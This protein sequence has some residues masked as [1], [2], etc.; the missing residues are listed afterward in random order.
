MNPRN[1]NSVSIEMLRGPCFGS[2]PVYSLT[3][4]GDGL[5][6]YRGIR[7]V[8]VKEKQTTRASSE[9]LMQVLR[10]LDRI[11]FFTLEDRAFLWC[12]DSSSA[13]ISVSVDGKQ[14]R[15]TTDNCN[16]GGNGGPKARFLQIADQIDTIAGSKQW[17][18]CNGWSCRN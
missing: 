1:I 4:H 6:E 15:V 5:V 14:K 12:F 10:D 16:V 11:H 8:R 3:L 2:C 13:S 7:F 9:Q 18:Q 17:V